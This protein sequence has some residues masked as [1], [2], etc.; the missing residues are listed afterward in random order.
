MRLLNRKTEDKDPLEERLEIISDLTKDLE[1][2]EFNCL[3][4][5]IKSMFEVRQKL[6][7]ARTK[8]EKETKIVDDITKDLMEEDLK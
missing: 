4:D 8:E 2:K 3:M 1:R 6:K 5:A 7:G